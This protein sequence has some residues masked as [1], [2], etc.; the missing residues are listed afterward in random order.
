MRRRQ[1]LAGLTAL[2]AG[3]VGLSSDDDREGDVGGGGSVTVDGPAVRYT[4][5]LATDADSVPDR[6]I[7]TGQPGAYRW[8]PVL[9][10]IQS[11][12]LSTRDLLGLSHITNG[13]RRETA[14]AAIVDEA[15][16]RP[17]DDG[18]RLGANDLATLWYRVPGDSEAEGWE[19]QPDQLRAEFDGFE[20]TAEPI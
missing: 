17:T 1:L 20:A 3:C 13:D 8:V 6:V 16:Y 14:R 7:Q 19:W 5:G 9:V 2:T 15:V 4:T 11:G 12:E 18:R 10:E